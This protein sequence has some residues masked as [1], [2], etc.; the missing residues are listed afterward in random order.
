MPRAG[1]R[2]DEEDPSVHQKGGGRGGRRCWLLRGG[3]A[4]AGRSGQGQSHGGAQAVRVREVGPAERVVVGAPPA[5][6][7]RQVE[8]SRQPKLLPGPREPDPPSHSRLGSGDGV[9]DNR[10]ARVA[11][12]VGVR[13]RVQAEQLARRGERDVQSQEENVEEDHGE[14]QQGALLK[15]RS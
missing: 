4:G 2:G 1:R 7:S 12:G 14:Q 6:G 11:H 8:H 3:G 13:W 15:V 9:G 5:D 10:P